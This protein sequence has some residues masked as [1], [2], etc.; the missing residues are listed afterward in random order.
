MSK[1]ELQLFKEKLDKGFFVQNLFEM[2]RICESLMK[3][4]FASPTFYILRSIF[5]DI[6]RDWNDR[7]LSVEEATEV[8]NELKAPIREALEGLETHRSKE[9]LFESL[10]KLVAARK[11]VLR[12]ATNR[13]FGL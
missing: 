5:L 8:E 3:D 13:Q 2:A 4:T 6:A 1:T 10:A 7:A 11:Q 12:T 9:A